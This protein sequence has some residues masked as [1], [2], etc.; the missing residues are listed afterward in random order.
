[1]ISMACLAW[2][3]TEMYN[4]SQGY[5]TRQKLLRV[6]AGPDSTCI[7]NTWESRWNSIGDR[8][9]YKSETTWEVG[10]AGSSHGLDMYRDVE[11]GA[12]FPDSLKRWAGGDMNGTSF[13]ESTSAID[14]ALRVFGGNRPETT[15]IVMSCATLDD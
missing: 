13:A 8:A 14:V 1:M 7:R 10:V 6:L 12:S 2:R 11:C 9:V 4:F 5:S 15:C 3:F